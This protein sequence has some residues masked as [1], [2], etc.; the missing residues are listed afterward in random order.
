MRTYERPS[1]QPDSEARSSGL[2]HVPTG[3]VSRVKEGRSYLFTGSYRFKTEDYD[4][5][6]SCQVM[7]EYR[8]AY[9]G[10]RS[11]QALSPL[12]FRFKGRKRPGPTLEDVTVTSRNV[13]VHLWDDGSIE[14]DVINVYVD[15]RSLAAN[16]ALQFRPKIR[17]LQFTIPSG[18]NEVVFSIEHVKSPSGANTAAV[19]FVGAVE[20]HLRQQGWHLTKPGQRASCLIT[21]KPPPPPADPSSPSPPSGPPP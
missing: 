20:A 14:D 18:Q 9:G 3:S 10:L 5:L 17:T 19:E 11:K 2:D 7:L 12:R 15:G 1:A 6:Y 8:R 13:T 21:Y 4:G 16:V